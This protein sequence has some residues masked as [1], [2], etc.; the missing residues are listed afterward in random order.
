MYSKC[1]IPIATSSGFEFGNQ[2]SKKKKLGKRLFTI[3]SSRH[4]KN[5]RVLCIVYDIVWANFALCS[6]CVGGG[7]AQYYPHS[8]KWSKEGP[9][10]ISSVRANEYPR[11]ASRRMDK[12]TFQGEVE[13]T[14]KELGRVREQ[15]SPRYFCPRCLVNL[16]IIRNSAQDNLITSQREIGRA[17]V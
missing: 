2:H 1:L 17:H 9:N 5:V 10:P 6:N 16:L 8:Y 11:T 13:H 15:R 4:H 7:Q 12:I 14:Y 3:T